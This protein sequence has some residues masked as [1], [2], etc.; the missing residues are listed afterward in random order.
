MYNATQVNQMAE[1]QREMDDRAET[2]EEVLNEAVA[3]MV[4][5]G[6]P[7]QVILFGSRARGDARPDSDYDFLVIEDS[8]LPR[9]RRAAKYRRAL[10]GLLPSKDIL[11][12]TPEEAAEWSA[13]S[14][15]LVTTAINEGVMLYEREG[16]SGQW[17]DCHLAPEP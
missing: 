8:S 9:Y 12:W 1:T 13:V 3:R 17:R 14:Q 11:V 6:D 15:A 16:S 5:A 7:L 2:T 10:T 4:A